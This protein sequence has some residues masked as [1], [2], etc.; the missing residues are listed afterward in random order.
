ME[1]DNLMAHNVFRTASN[2]GFTLNF[3]VARL[4][5]FGCNSGTGCTGASR[6]LYTMLHIMPA[7]ITD[8]ST[9]HFISVP[10]AAG[11]AYDFNTL[12]NNAD[13]N[14]IQITVYNNNLTNAS[15]YPITATDFTLSGSYVAYATYSYSDTT[16]AQ[17]GCIIPLNISGSSNLVGV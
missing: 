15:K 7:L 13:V 6:T 1:F 10:I 17:T 8:N 3:S 4:K 12:S 14:F 16:G 11:S 9:D 5:A 2:T